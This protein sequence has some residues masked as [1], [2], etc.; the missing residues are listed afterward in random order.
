MNSCYIDVLKSSKLNFQNVFLPHLSLL[1]FKVGD[2]TPQMNKCGV[3]RNYSEIKLN[4]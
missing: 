3:L 2:R 4:W 1:I